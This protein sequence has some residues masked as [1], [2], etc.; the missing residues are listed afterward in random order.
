MKKTIKIVTAA[1][2]AWILFCGSVFAEGNFT[3]QGE[4][5][6]FSE[7]FD[8]RTIASNSNGATVEQIDGRDVLKL[9]GENAHLSMKETDTIEYGFSADIRMSD[10]SSGSYAGLSIG[11]D[12]SGAYRLLIYPKE[13]KAKILKNNTI[14]AEKKVDL[15]DW[16]NVKIAV[17]DGIIRAMM[18]NA[19]VM[20]VYDA[21]PLSGMGS[22]VNANGLTAYFA[23]VSLETESSYY[24]ENFE[25]G[26]VYSVN[27]DEIRPTET[28]G[29]TSGE[30]VVQVDEG[31]NVMTTKGYSAYSKIVYPFA[32]KRAE[33]QQ[34]SCS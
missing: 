10:A 9:S 27:S 25:S 8:S 15:G 23:S 17:K 24:Y 18:N 5:N 19:V 33:Q 30:W 7:S 2:A 11:E 34:R 16:N 31:K 14:L 12:N 29:D 20:T 1:L 13:K 4:N 6:L 32:K 26:A 21:T 28:K 3:Y 22:S